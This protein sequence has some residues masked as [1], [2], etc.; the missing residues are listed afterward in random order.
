MSSPV[1]Q[2]VI[3]Y[4]TRLAPVSE[5][6]NATTRAIQTWSYKPN[7]GPRLPMISAYST[8]LNGFLTPVAGPPVLPLEVSCPTGNCQF[9]RFSSLGVCVQQK[10]ITD[11]LNVTTSSPPTPDQWPTVIQLGNASFQYNVSLGGDCSM[12]SPSTVAFKTCKTDA[13]QS[14]AFQNDWELM[15]AKIYSFPLIYT[16]IEDHMYA[17]ITDPAPVRWAA[18]EIFFHLCVNTYNISVTDGHTT[19]QAVSS[20]SGPMKD[21]DRP[22]TMQ[23]NEMNTASDSLQCLTPEEDK[24]ADR[25]SYITLANPDKPM[26]ENTSDYFG[27]QRAVMNSLMDALHYT[28]EGLYMYDPTDNSDNGLSPNSGNMQIIEALF[29]NDNANFNE[30]K[31]LDLDVQVSRVMLIMN[32]TVNALTNLCVVPRPPVNPRWYMC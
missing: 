26:S 31:P 15:A 12:L 9:P 17:N 14:Y 11:L 16:V 29:N 19:T 23:C 3:S 30:T 24:I 25:T 20:W 21:T 32:N 18:M 7:V 27:A 8:V 4:P 22:L 1:T 28:S 5:V 13:N 10:N 2:Q 6:G